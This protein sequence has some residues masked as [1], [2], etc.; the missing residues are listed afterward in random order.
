MARRWVQIAAF[1]VVVLASLV[2]LLVPTYE[3]AKSGSGGT[4]V[5]TSQSMLEVNGPW[6]LVL[7]TM[8]IVFTAVPLIV[9]G[10]IGMIASVVSTALL[11][12]F[13]IISLI[14]I[15]IFFVPGAILA[16]VALCLPAG[17]AVIAK[18]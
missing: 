14:T 16:V 7:L 13:V 18:A 5:V 9:H 1:A 3:S 10:R 6:L 8:P 17:S 12:L 15:G 2:L 11:V 4:E